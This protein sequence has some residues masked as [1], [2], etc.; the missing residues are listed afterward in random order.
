MSGIQLKRQELASFYGVTTRTVHDWEK[1]GLKVMARG[2]GNRSSIYNSLDAH[3]F[4]VGR[5]IS[6]RV[7]T[8]GDEQ[9]D[10]NEEEARLKHHQA[11]NEA[12]KEA[13]IIGRLVDSRM[14]VELC[15]GLVGNARSKILAI[16]NSVKNRYPNIDQAIIDDIEEQEIEAL[17]ELGEDG[18]PPNLNRIMERYNFGMDS[19]TEINGK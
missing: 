4:M 17:N 3:D 12:L 7:I 6:K 18:I 9:Y 14:V 15:A 19:A 10:K 13:E 11:N 5:E 8:T 2:G 1:A 16:H